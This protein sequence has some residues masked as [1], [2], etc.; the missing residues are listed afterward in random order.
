MDGH[1]D[2]MNSTRAE[3]AG[4]ISPLMN[5]LHI[6][7]EYKVTSGTLHMH[8]DNTRSYRK[9]N[10]PKMGDETFR[11]V[12]SDY[13]LKLHKSSLEHKLRMDHNIT[14]EYHHMKAHQDTTPLKDT[15]GKMIPLT[16]AA[17]LNIVCDKMAE[18]E[19]INPTPGHE[20]HINPEMVV[21]T[22]VYFESK[23]ITNIKTLCTQIHIHT[24]E[25]AQI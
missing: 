8:V 12:I 25:D 19:R 20:L 9:G 24:H 21:N 16:K 15:K 2:F 23:G 10:A 17:K 13:D 7:Q 18:E 6:A 5:T 14:V 4:F 3:R 11:H 22:K 1:S